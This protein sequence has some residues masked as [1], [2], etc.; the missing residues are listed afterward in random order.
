MRT[1]TLAAAGLAAVVMACAPAVQSSADAINR[2]EQDRA[3]HPTSEAAVR[4]LGIAYFK[5]NR[6][7]D[8]R[9]ALQQAVTMDAN[10][11]V[12][13]LY[14]GLTAEAQNDLPAAKTAYAAYLKVGRTRRVRAQLEARLAAIQ[15]RELELELK[16]SI[17]DEQ[18]LASVPGPPNTVAVLPF[19]FSGP[20]TSLKPLERG[21]AELLTTD[22]SVS[23]RL[24]VLDRSRTQ[25][26]LDEIKLQQSGATDEN[27]GV[28]AGRILRAGR[29]VRGSLL[30][31][32]N[33]LRTDALVIDVPTTNTAGEAADNR[34]LDQLFTMEK[35]IALQLFT[36]MGVSLTTAQRNSIEQRPTKSLAAFLAYSRGLELEDRGEYDAANRSYQQAVRIDPGFNKAQ[37]KVTQTQAVISGN[38]VSAST[39]EV[40]L[41]GTSEGAEVQAATGQTT[42]P[43]NTAQNTAAGLNPSTAGNA[44]GAGAT[45]TGSQPTTKNGAAEG[46][47]TNRPGNTTAIVSLTI[48][49]PR[50]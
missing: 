50:P 6:F 36:T 23:D 24:T 32:G 3:A 19:A 41:K 12:A 16:K 2:L 39:V 40:G 49:Q 29:L 11:G 10:D 22:L 21:F 28:R 34:A 25:A 43:T 26:L 14:L 33:Q 15:R 48:P 4:S 7:A 35:N 46:T 27:T 45:T 37:Q 9:P 38:Q 44:T 8:A 42:S 31:Q 13:A 5:A 20:D 1:T 30:Q 18:Q 47:G 17:V